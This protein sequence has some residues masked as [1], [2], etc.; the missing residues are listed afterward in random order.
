MAAESKA[1]AIM[2][3]PFH[4]RRMCC[5]AG[6]MRSSSCSD[7]R[8]QLEPVS[9]HGACSL[10]FLAAGPAVAT[11]QGRQT[12]LQQRRRRS[13]AALAAV[14]MSVVA[15]GAHACNFQ[16]RIPTRSRLYRQR[17]SLRPAAAP[18]MITEF[19][20]IP[21][22]QTEQYAVRPVGGRCGGGPLWSRGYYRNAVATSD[23]VTLAATMPLPIV[24]KS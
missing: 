10:P 3:A 8:A 13:R 16:V 4:V 15:L 7:A 17:L 23:Y 18:G 1:V 24:P 22:E 5:L 11:R 6:S 21:V 9:D 20:L 14:G 12:W 19:L 2:T